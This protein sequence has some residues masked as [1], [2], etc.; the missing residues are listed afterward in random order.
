MPAPGEGWRPPAS[1]RL[2]TWPTGDRRRPGQARGLGTA[3]PRQALRRRDRH[4]AHALAH[5][6][7]RPRGQAAAGSHRPSGRGHR[8]P[9][10]PGHRRQPA[11]APGPRRGATPTAYRAAYQGRSRTPARQDP[12]H[13]WQSCHWPQSR[14]RL[15]MRRVHPDHGGLS[16]VEH[17]PAP[18]PQPGVR[19]RSRRAS[20]H[21]QAPV[22]PN[23]NLYIVTCIDCRVDPAQIL[24]VKLGEALVQRNIGGRITPAV[25]ATSHTPVTWSTARPRKARTSRSRS[26]TTRTAA[27]PCSPTTNCATG[28]PGASA[29]TS[30]PWPIRRSLTRPARCGPMSSG[31]CGRTKFL[32]TSASPGTSTTSVRRGDH[33]R[34]RE[35]QEVDRAG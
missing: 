1:G 20:G 2:S 26:S 17:R 27:R 5:R 30:G 13:T 29:R 24:G 23:L 33:H 34:R 18:G 14:P 15:T 6:R 8:R 3:L 31:C 21:A 35:R 32:R 11:S 19:Q 9:L 28:S 4:G 22:H 16:L 7:P 10:R 12:D 25:I